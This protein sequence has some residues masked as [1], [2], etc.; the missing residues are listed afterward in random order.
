MVVVECDW[1]F[2]V[3][4]AVAVC[5]L[6]SASRDCMDRGSDAITLIGCRLRD[7]GGGVVGHDVASSGCRSSVDCS[8]RLR[9]AVVVAGEAPRLRSGD[10]GA[11]VLGGVGGFACG[12]YG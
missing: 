2:D 4:A 8:S 6:M 7:S 12:A 10:V 3:D 1:W 5:R 11:G 9:I